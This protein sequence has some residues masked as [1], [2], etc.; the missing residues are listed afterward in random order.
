M[1]VLTFKQ[2]NF[3]WNAEPNA[4]F[5]RVSKYDTDILLQFF[6]NSS[7][8]P[9]FRENENGALRFSKAAKFR[10]GATNDEGWYLGQ[11]RYSH[12]VPRWGQFYE[13]I[14][15]DPVC[16][17]PDDWEVIALP[18]AAKRHFLFYLRDDT[19]EVFADDWSFDERSDNAL[20]RLQGNVRTT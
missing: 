9:Q 11:C 1:S 4:P 5:P 13:L 3:G 7:Q 2:L 17:D 10:V 18:D 14:G 15:S 19:F 16:D 8:F 6:L 12:L 20:L